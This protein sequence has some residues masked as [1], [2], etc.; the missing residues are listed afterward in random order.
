MSISL[1]RGLFTAALLLVSA[2]SLAQKPAAPAGEET[3]I[4]QAAQS[5]LDALNRGDAAALTAALAPGADFVDERGHRYLIADL[6]KKEFAQPGEAAVKR[7]LESKTTVRLLTSDVAIEDGVTETPDANGT[8][9]PIG[10]FTATWV[11]RDGRWLLASLREAAIL[12]EPEFRPIDELDW[13]IG[14]W[15]AAHDDLEYVMNARW[16]AG[17]HFILRD[18]EVRRGGQ[19]LMNANQRIGWDPAKKQIH[20][21]S[22]DE[23]GGHGEGLW[24]EHEGVWHNKTEGVLPNGDEVTSIATYTPQEDG[25]VTWRVERSGPDEKSPPLELKLSRQPQ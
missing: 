17:R 6:V 21:W 7:N 18:F 15:T 3:A 11:K 10:R 22:F 25:T 1:R 12:P 20:S 2:T 5:Y 19:V 4:R 8:P 13:M 9:T 16:D 14:T 23:A 24:V